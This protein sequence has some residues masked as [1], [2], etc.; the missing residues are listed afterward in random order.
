MGQ[1]ET[2]VITDTKLRLL[3][4]LDEAESKALDSLSRYK[5]QMFGYHAA[6]W[7]TL[8]RI[9]GLNRPNPFAAFVRIARTLSTKSVPASEVERVS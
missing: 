1:G 8:N 9:S 7:V 4:A 3:K 5:F 6:T 2:R